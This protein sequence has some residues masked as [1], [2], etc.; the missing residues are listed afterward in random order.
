MC[1]QQDLSTE[2]HPPDT[3]THT[4]TSPA[5]THRPSQRGWSSWRP[6]RF[7]GRTSEVKMSSPS[8]VQRKIK[9][10]CTLSV[11]LTKKNQKRID[12]A[13][14]C[15]T[16]FLR[17][18]WQAGVR[19]RETSCHSPTCHLLVCDADS[20]PLFL[21]ICYSLTCSKCELLSLPASLLHTSLTC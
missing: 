7:P 4:Y 6:T 12:F 3:H 19:R 14:C 17:T 20:Q 2:G 21:L 15:S 10:L 1:D 8:F 13:C 16:A 11:P 9:P 5:E 18:R